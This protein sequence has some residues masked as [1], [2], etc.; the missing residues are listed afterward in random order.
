MKEARPQDPNKQEERPQGPNKQELAEMFAKSISK[1]GSENTWLVLE[2]DW[3]GSIFLTIPW[4]LIGPKANI[5]KLL[6]ELDQA[7][8]GDCN[9]GE[10]GSIHITSP[11]FNRQLNKEISEESDTPL[12]YVYTP[13]DYVFGGMGGGKMLPKA[14]WLLEE[15]QDK[16]PRAKELLDY[17]SS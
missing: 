1:Y 5:G 4:E 8:W 10:G 2:G 13:L 6:R 16:M 14:I 11:E 12:D 9:E 3:G 15:I 17:Q 7:V